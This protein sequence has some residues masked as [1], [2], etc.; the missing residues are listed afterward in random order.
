M[1]FLSGKILDVLKKGAEVKSADGTVLALVEAFDKGIVLAIVEPNLIDE[2]A[3]E[4]TVIL[5]R[6]AP[7]PQTAFFVVTKIVSGKTAKAVN[8]AF[9]R[10]LKNMHEQQMR[11]AEHKAENGGMIG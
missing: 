10:Q 5:R 4:Q 8:D 2:I 6:E 3:K 7:N 9:A 11:L 1:A